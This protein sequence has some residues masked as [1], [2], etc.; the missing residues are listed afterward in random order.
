MKIV[1]TSSQQN[2]YKGVILYIKATPVFGDNLLCECFLT[3]VLEISRA[4]ETS[5]Q[6]FLTGS[7]CIL[8][9]FL[10]CYRQIRTKKALKIVIDE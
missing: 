6:V 9:K 8:L 7:C 4:L 5:K 10:P 2:R 3:I 1:S